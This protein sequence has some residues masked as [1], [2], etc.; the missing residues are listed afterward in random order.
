M[1]PEIEEEWDNH[2]SNNAFKWLRQMNARKKIAR[3]ESCY[4]QSLRDKIEIFAKN[5]TAKELMLKDCILV[6]GAI[7]T[8][9]II[10]SL[11][12]K[13][14]TEFDEIAR[15]KVKA[16]K[17]IMWSNPTKVE[18]ECILWLEKGAKNEKKRKL[19]QN[20]EESE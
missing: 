3:L 15:A 12:E 13:A 7:K 2:A 5:E 1:T 4:D 20:L 14:R 8:D 10:F 11:D 17:V 19:G 6:E 9:K 16:L 18:E